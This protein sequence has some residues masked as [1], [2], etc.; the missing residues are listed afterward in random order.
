MY[1]WPSSSFQVAIFC[2]VS[3]GDQNRGGATK[4]PRDVT[5][6]WLG[7]AAAARGATSA[8]GH[9]VLSLD[10]I[11]AGAAGGSAGAAARGAAAAAGTVGR[12]AIVP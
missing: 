9:R 3:T 7:S 2:R 5:P 6:F 11:G 1:C 10:V 8:S 12:A 4:R